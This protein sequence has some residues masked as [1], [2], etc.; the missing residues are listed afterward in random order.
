MSFVSLSMFVTAG[1]VVATTAAA[2][3]LSRWTSSSAMSSGSAAFERPSPAVPPLV[4]AHR[5]ASGYR[6][7]HTIEAYQ[8]A[9][10]QG[11]DFIEP[12]LVMTAD[13]QLIAR[14]EPMLAVWDEAGGRWTD[15][16]TDVIDRPE[17]KDRLTTRM[18]E[19]KP[20]TAFWAED[21][22]L[23][24]IKTLRARERLPLNRPGNVAFN[25]RFDIPTLDE[26]IALAQKASAETGRTV[27]IYP[28]TKHPTY[29]AE[30]SRRRGLP[31]MES[32]LLKTLHAAYGNVVDAPVFIQSFETAN[33]RA[34]RAQT[35]LRLV[36]LL[37]DR[38]R[39]WDFEVAGD[40]RTYADLATP[41]GLAEIAA[42]ADGVGPHKNLVRPR[43]PDGTLGGPTGLVSA[44]RALGLV[45]HP[46]TF[47]AENPFLPPALR[48]GDRPDVHGDAAGELRAFIDAGVH[49]VFTDHPDIARSVLSAP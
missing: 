13:G 49:G 10:E 30:M 2:L 8:L 47:R 46:W 38:G 44:A 18:L 12:D 27:G 39:P 41:E 9:I 25:D 36:Q 23:E 19:G 3:A 16:T 21:F 31:T 6:P 24:E 5:G 1:M 32:V 42:Y 22:T 4:I 11:A 15:V 26:I 48:S 7:E 17:F 34:M 43:N 28:E 33:L 37:A 20:I 14:H 29:H 35:R 40:P 45:V